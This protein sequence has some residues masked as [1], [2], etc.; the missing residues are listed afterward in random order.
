MNK[1]KRTPALLLA[2]CLFAALAVPA[3]ALTEDDTPVKTVRALGIMVGDEKGNMNLGANVTRAQFAKMMAAASTYKDTVGT[4]GTGYSLYKDVKNDHWASE[5]IRLAAQQ[6]WM[7]G[8]LDG[9]FQP[10]NTITLEEACATVLRLLGYDSASL[11]G[12]YPQAQ[13]SKASALDLRKGISRSQG[14]QMSRSDCAQLFYNLLTAEDSSGKV[15]AS[16]LGYTVTNGE[17][18]YTAIMLDKL[19][20]P[21][22]A[23]ANEAL[24]FT[25]ASVYRDGKESSSAAL[26]QYDVYYYNQALNSLWIYTKRVSGR[27]ELISMG[28]SSSNAITTAAASISDTTEAAGGSSGAGASGMAKTP[29]SVRISGKSYTVGTADAAYHLSTLS[30][31]TT[32]SYVTLLLGMND[33]VVDVLVGSAVNGF[34]YGVVQSYTRTVNEDSAAVQTDVKVF[35]MDGVSRTFTVKRDAPLT[36]GT[37]AEV[38]VTDSGVTVKNLGT[39]RVTGRISSDGTRLD[40]EKLADNIRI[41]DAGSH[42]AAKVI[43]PIRLANVSLQQKDVRYYTRNTAGEID[44]LIL[45]DATG[46]TWTYAYLIDTVDNSGDISVS[47]TYTWII[48]GERTTL[49]SSGSKYAVNGG[50]VALVYGANGSTLSNMRQLTSVRL[51]SINADASAAMAENRAFRLADGVQVYL[52]QGGELLSA[53]AS[54]VNGEDYRLT[55]WYDDF[56]GSAGGLIRIL[57]AEPKAA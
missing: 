47:V 31:I 34:Y 18:D 30:G 51:T 6:G 35:C 28:T 38:N 45:N 56:T 54:A 14:E 3:F 44:N 29:T 24:P 49:P 4:G 41:I 13:L 5:Y 22:V 48:D 11:A 7:R 50:A 37:V 9:S 25:P 15:Y 17:L 46:D 36:A 43:D 12:S 8:Y 33:V 20:G 39:Q 57:I 52:R 19:S 27:V 53:D 16:S 42:G 32:D 21:Y 10:E 23:G 1:K 26:K 2:L 40:S 55:G